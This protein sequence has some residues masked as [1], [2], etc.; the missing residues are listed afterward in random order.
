MAPK[1]EL[2]AAAPDKV[3]ADLL[4][5]PV[6]SGPTLGPGADV[7]DRALGGTLL[8]FMAE[9]GFEA[10]RGDVLA[11]PTGGQLGAKAAV[12]VGMGDPET[13]DAD[14]MRRAGASLARRASKV[15]KVATTLLDV[16]PDALDRAEAAQALAE[17]VVLGAYQ[18]LVY[19]SEAKPSRLTRVQVLGRANAMVRDGLA[20]GARIAQA[21]VWARDLVNEPAEAKSPETIVKLSRALARA[22]GL[23]VRVWAGEQ[24]VRE[25]LGGV[26]GVGIGSERPPR[27]LRLA[28]EPRG[29]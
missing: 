15:Q 5:V 22:N 4:A 29:A 21:V 20:R 9:T 8:A 24:L 23:T 12:L 13:L 10:K 3:R 14:A 25:R 18:F 28:Y 16:A 1:I 17:G 27:F 26:V 2:V 19:K 7:V 6:F 11:V